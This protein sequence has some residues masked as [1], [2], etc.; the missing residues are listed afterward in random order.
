MSE[1]EADFFMW[2]TFMT[3]PFVDSNELRPLGFIDTP[4]HCFGFVARASWLSEPGNR[5]L[6]RRA[7]AAALASAEAF[8]GDE[9]P[10]CEDIS[11]RFGLSLTDAHAWLRSVRYV[12]KDAPL[13][14]AAPMLHQ[15]LRVLVSV[16]VLPP[17]GD[18]GGPAA[19]YRLEDLCDKCVD[20]RDGPPP[21][22]GGGGSGGGGGGGGGGA[23][24]WEPLVP[25][26]GHALRP[27]AASRVASPASSAPQSPR[28]GS[29]V[30][31]GGDDG[32][33]EGMGSRDFFMRT[34]RGRLNVLGA[35]HEVA[36]SHATHVVGGQAPAAGGTYYHLPTAAG[37]GANAPPSPPQ[38][39]VGGAPSGARGTSRYEEWKRGKH[40]AL[41]EIMRHLDVYGGAPSE[42]P[43]PEA[44]ER[45]TPGKGGNT[46]GSPMPWASGMG[47]DFG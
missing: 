44:L 10:A 28:A 41:L 2:E 39:H 40:A 22:D 32:V 21:L 12:R 11:A 43:P 25:S 5:E 46:P 13:A 1:G 33:E 18:G 20:L 36:D 9:D 26:V 23:P 35:A 7:G 24:W 47:A 27:R 16:G 3:K 42:R 19:G 4:W 34:V 37:S 31:L 8:L 38:L 14:A 6:L 17:R 15:V 30:V 45:A 29:P